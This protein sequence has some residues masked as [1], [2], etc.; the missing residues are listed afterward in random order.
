MKFGKTDRNIQVLTANM[1]S[2]IASP[3]AF[4]GSYKED[5]SRPERT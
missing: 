5:W 1:A 4:V 3:G 2:R